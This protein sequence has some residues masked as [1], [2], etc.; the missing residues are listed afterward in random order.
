VILDHDLHGL[1]R[2]RLIDPSPQARA[3]VER[4]LGTPGQPPVGE[5]D[6]VVRFVDAVPRRGR[7]RLIGVEEM[8]FTDDSFV[9]LRRT[10]AGTA[11]VTMPLDALGG[12]CEIECDRGI[13]EV[14]LLIPL[15]N[16]AL[17]NK[18]VLPVHASAF[19][20]RGEGIVAA[21]WRQSGKTETLLGFMAHGAVAVADEWCYITND[22]S[23]YGIP[24]PVRLQDWHLEQLPQHRAAVGWPTRL[25][26]GAWRAADGTGQAARRAADHGM[27]GARSLSRA[28]RAAA[29][30]RHVDM[31]PSALFGAEGW[32]GRGHL[33]RAFLLLSVDAPDVQVAPSHGEEVADRMVF[34]HQHH[35]LNVLGTGLA[36]RFAFPQR[37]HAAIDN[38]E[39]LERSLLRAAFAD[40]PCFV[41]EHPYPIPIETT[42]RAIEE[43]CG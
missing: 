18:G 25:R 34:A 9:L 5:A 16:L 35:R 10:A 20:Y 11:L 15:I 32:S 27:P 22:G 3:A 4:Q 1:L 29:P 21:G 39:E 7:L 37:H 43:H 14:P 30:R 6:L 36:A 24:E 17:V 28:L 26:L 33:D 12:S 38:A 2:V 19:T 31:D 13:R 23:M 42:F 41:V 8:G 40:V